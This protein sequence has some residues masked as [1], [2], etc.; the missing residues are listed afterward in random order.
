M[1]QLVG[2]V[3]P[4]NSRMLALAKDLGFREA[5]IDRDAVRVVLDL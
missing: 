3:L 1:C 2:A 4:E 5:K